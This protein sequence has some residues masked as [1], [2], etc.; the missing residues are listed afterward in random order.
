MFVTNCVNLATGHLGEGKNSNVPTFTVGM[1]ISRHLKIHF[2][3]SSGVYD[4]I[5]K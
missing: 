3:Y 2:D 5:T 1:S 4:E